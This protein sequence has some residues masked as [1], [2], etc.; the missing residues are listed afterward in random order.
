MRKHNAAISIA[1]LSLAAVA[2]TSCG[3]NGSSQSSYDPNDTGDLTFDSNG[4]IF[5]EGVNLTMWS[6]TTGDD[7]TTQDQ[8]VGA[9]NELYDGMIHVEVTHTSRYDLEQLLNTT[10]QFDRQSAPDL[11][12]NHGSRAAEYNERGWILPVDDYFTRSGVSFDKQDFV[13]SLLEAVTLDGKAYGMPIDCHSAVVMMRTDILEKNGYEIPTNYAELVAICDDAAEKAAKNE[14]WIRGENSQGY[15]AT[16]WRKASTAE[17]YTAFPI[18]YG[19][20]W[21]HEFVGYTAAIQNGAELIDDEG[22]PAWD[23]EQAA[24]GLQLLR[25]WI[26]ATPGASNEHPLS[27]DY[28]SSYDVGES[29]FLTGNAIFKLQGPWVYAKDKSDFDNLLRNDGGSSN[30]TTR[31][32]SSLFAAD[33]NSEDADKIKGEGHAIMLMSTVESLTKKCAAT[34]FMDYMAYYS[35]IDWAKRGHLPAAT[36]VSNS[37]AY[38]EDPAYEEYIKYWGDPSDYVVFEPTV[39]YS[40]VDQYFKSALQKSLASDFLSTPVKSILDSEY[41]DCIAY[42]QLY[43]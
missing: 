25:D 11:L 8:I 5:Y 35:G 43:S 14:L 6:V 3:G 12:F 19:D 4:Q 10:M 16:E 18:A 37:S 23:S 29:P 41:E 34:V 15:A 22:M 17:A 2:A 13:P 28:G 32:L 42:I 9:F 40:Y 38:R 7:A 33:P 21:V 26:H 30:I 39:N 24:T 20:M 31:S 36:S 27:K 1:A